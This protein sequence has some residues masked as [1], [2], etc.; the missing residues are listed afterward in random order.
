MKIPSLLL[1]VG[2][3][4]GCAYYR[5]LFGRGENPA[6]AVAATEQQLAREE[7]AVTATGPGRRVPCSRARTSR[8]NIC[9]LAQRTCLLAARDRSIP[10]GRA[11]CQKAR[12]KCQSAHQRAGSSCKTT[13]ATRTAQR[14]S[15]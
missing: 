13:R 4:S 8:D 14:R 6:G 5:T 12:S 3:F 9:T 2:A 15:R 10:D 1:I 11:R 7:A